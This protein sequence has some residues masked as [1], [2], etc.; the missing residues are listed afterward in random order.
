MATSREV[1]N[2]HRRVIR[3]DRHYQTVPSSPAQHQCTQEQHNLHTHQTSTS[4]ET[5]YSRASLILN[6]HGESK[7]IS[8][9]SLAELFM[10]WQHFKAFISLWYVLFPVAAFSTCSFFSFHSN[11]LSA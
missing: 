6:T 1:E 2:D 9:S 5:A 10:M 4:A 11:N 3:E 8:S 7:E